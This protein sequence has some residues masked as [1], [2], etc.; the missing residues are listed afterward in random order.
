MILKTLPIVSEINQLQELVITVS[1][2]MQFLDF[3]QL[4]R[5]YCNSASAIFGFPVIM[6]VKI[7]AITY[8]LDIIHEKKE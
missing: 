2:K 1:L 4:L 3:L 8:T 5:S 7:I 6:V